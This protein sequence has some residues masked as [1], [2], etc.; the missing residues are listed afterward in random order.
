M[1][2][3]IGLDTD[4]NQALWSAATYMHDS[5]G[6]ARRAILVLTDNMQETH[7]PD[8]LVNEQLADAAAVL[9]GFLLRGPVALPHVTRPGILGFARNSGG[10]IIEG[11]QPGA[12]LA[13][14]IRRIK[15]RYSIHF[16]PA[17]A[18]STKPR[19]I[20]VELTDEARRRYPDAA[21]RA[22]R[23]Y[24]PGG[25]FRPKLD[26]P[27][28]QGIAAVQPGTTSAFIAIRPLEHMLQRL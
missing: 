15:F 25:V 6:T 1:S 10:E 5:G 14:M 23:I 13:E 22:R 12:H 21:I 28:T 4:I 3:R 26:I 17:A 18:S 27:T 19:R 9:N 11:N 7:V 24:F 8:S 2:A 20:R 16:P